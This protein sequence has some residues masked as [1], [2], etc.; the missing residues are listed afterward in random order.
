[1]KSMYNDSLE[2]VNEIS[3]SIKNL[4]DKIFGL[5]MERRDRHHDLTQ[6]LLKNAS[7]LEGVLHHIPLK[8]IQSSI[9]KL[10]RR[11]KSI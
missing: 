9:A 2:R 7:I 4:D 3:T 8:T 6:L 5:T 11:M 1:M 10:N